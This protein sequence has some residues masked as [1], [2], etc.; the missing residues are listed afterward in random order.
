MK[1]PFP[2]AYFQAQAVGFREGTPLE[3]TD[4]FLLDSKNDGNSGKKWFLSTFFQKYG[5]FVV[6]EV[7][8][9]RVLF[10]LLMESGQHPQ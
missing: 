6:L 9:F 1:G 3:Q 7:L 5:I 10:I 2:M 4:V 8:V